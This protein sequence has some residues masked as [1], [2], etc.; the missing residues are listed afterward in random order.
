MDFQSALQELNEQLKDAVSSISNVKHFNITIE[1]DMKV[2]NVQD[3]T[4]KIAQV[5]SVSSNGKENTLFFLVAFQCEDI[6][7]SGFKIASL[8]RT[9]NDED[10]SSMLIMD[11]S[12]S[13]I[14]ESVQGLFMNHL[15]GYSAAFYE[16]LSNAMMMEGEDE[17]E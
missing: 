6:S 17:T 14:L 9:E 13:P 1:S 11:S 4:E 3:S 10:G 12:F 5:I 2:K 8:K 15:E 7:N 16:G